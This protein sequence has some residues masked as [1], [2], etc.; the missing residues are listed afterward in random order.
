[1]G[2][3]VHSTGRLTMGMVRLS[4]FLIMSGICLVTR[5]NAVTKCVRCSS[6]VSSKFYDANCESGSGSLAVTNCDL[7]YSAGCAAAV[8][9]NHFVRDCCHWTR[10]R[11]SIFKRPNCACMQSFYDEN[12]LMIQSCR[13]GN[14]CNREN[15]LEG[16]NYNKLT[17]P[18]CRGHKS[19]TKA[20]KYRTIDVQE[21]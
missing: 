9:G 1:M 12:I 11:S 3:V 5:I 15:F 7:R 10:D 4:Y 13:N 18:F 20:E 19:D 6:D 17:R 14:T 21:P 2:V 16:Q 8:V